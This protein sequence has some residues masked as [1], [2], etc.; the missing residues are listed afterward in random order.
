[1]DSSPLVAVK[2]DVGRNNLVAESR[3]F[4]LYCG[5]GHYPKYWSRDNLQNL[6]KWPFILEVVGRFE[7]TAIEIDH[8]A[9]YGTDLFE[10]GVD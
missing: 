10:R 5:I 9:V 2:K 1:M 7:V 8:S 6:H 4:C 3:R